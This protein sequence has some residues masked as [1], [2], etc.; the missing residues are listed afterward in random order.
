M[1]DIAEGA[2]FHMTA[3]LRARLDAA[4]PG[5]VIPVPAG[6]YQGPLVLTKPVT[7]RGAAGASLVA[8]HGPVLVV[9]S[10]GVVLEN[11][12]IEVGDSAAEGEAGCALQVNAGHPVS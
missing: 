12:M 11:L 4:A 5:A 6:E 3:D 10:P 1:L 8:Q 2:V 7:L 9:D